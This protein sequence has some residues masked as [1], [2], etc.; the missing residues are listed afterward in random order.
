M[1]SLLL[2]Y[3]R[4]GF[5]GVRHAADIAGWWDRHGATLEPGFLAGYIENFPEIEPALVAAATAAERL[6]GVPATSWLGDRPEPSGRVAAAARLADWAQA[7][8]IDQMSAN[9]SLAGALLRPP[10]HTGEFARRDFL[11]PGE[12]APA[13]A[14]HA[15]KVGLRYALALWRVRGSRD[16]TAPPPAA[17]ERLSAAPGVQH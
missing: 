1:A 7:D 12:R 8:D 10:G 14:L 9:I 11:M 3:A 6:T 16:W 13:V 4:D 2:F 15:A 5:H 17:G